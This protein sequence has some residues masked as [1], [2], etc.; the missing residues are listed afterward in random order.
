MIESVETQSS[1]RRRAPRVWV[2]GIGVLRSGV[3]PPSVWRVSNLSSGGVGLVGDGR[4]ETGRH[5]LELHVAGFE[6][7]ELAVKVLRRQLLTRGGR[8]GVRFLDVTEPQQQALGEMIGADHAPSIVGRRALVVTPDRARARALDGELRPLGFSVRAESTPGQAGAWL[9]REEAEVVLVDESV[10]EVD[11]WSL[12]HFVRETAPEVRRLVIARDVRG[13][14]L[15]Y[16]IK[17]GL[18][19]GLVEPEMAPE[20]LARHLTGVSVAQSARRRR[21]AR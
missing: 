17:A 11:R 7:L 19:D 15:Y 9:Q 12:L 5:A 4:L 21:A 3:Q 18:V 13:F 8:C 2:A 10:V 6:P 16:A 20:A 1:E 14:R